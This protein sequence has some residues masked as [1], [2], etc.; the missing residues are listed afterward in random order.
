VIGAIV[1]GIL[2]GI[3]CY[4]FALATLIIRFLVVAG[5][6]AAGLK[7]PYDRS[8]ITFVSNFQASSATA[9]LMVAT[10]GMALILRPPVVLPLGVMAGSVTNAAIVAI[11]SLTRAATGLQSQVAIS[12]SVPEG[13]LL[14]LPDTWVLFGCVIPLPSASSLA[15]SNL[16]LS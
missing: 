13:R 15:A 3:A 14:Q 1:I 9:W 2:A 6:P 12:L 5:G 7:S 11:P 8:A 4:A 16:S 10:F